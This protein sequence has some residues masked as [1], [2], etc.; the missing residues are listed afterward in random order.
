MIRF[1]ADII[2]QETNRKLEVTQR[3]GAVIVTE[4]EQLLL[5]HLPE[6]GVEASAFF[7]QT[8]ETAFGDTILIATRN[9]GK[10]KEFRK[11]FEKSVSRL[12][13]LMIILIYQKLKKL[14]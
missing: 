1:V 12:K 11:M 8:S 10:T 4:A 5:V 9:E 13:I 3:A 14:A 6:N 2:N 7:G